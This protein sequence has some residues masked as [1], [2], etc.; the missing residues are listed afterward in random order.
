MDRLL[1]II[2]GPWT[3][4]ILW[5]LAI[6]GSVRFGEL[7]RLVTGVSS[8]VLT[9]RLRMLEEVGL[10]TRTHKPTIPP[11]VSYALSDRG[12][13][14]RGILIQLSDLSIK[15]DLAAGCENSALC[16]G[17]ENLPATKSA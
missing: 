15:W 7:K 10:I 6:H 8:R 5:R 4:Y 11:E 3:T 17:I 14:L 13:E 16:Q 1:Q 2:S 9:E 12:W